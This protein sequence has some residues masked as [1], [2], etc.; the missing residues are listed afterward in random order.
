MVGGGTLTSRGLR[1]RIQLEMAVVDQDGMK[2][3]HQVHAHQLMKT[4][5]HLPLLQH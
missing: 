4:I 5:K 2:Q 1:N 3:M